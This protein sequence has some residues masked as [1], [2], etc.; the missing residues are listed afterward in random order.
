MDFAEN[1]GISMN[2]SKAELYTDVALPAEELGKDEKGY[3]TF[4]NLENAAKFTFRTVEGTTLTGQD[5]I[6]S[7]QQ[8]LNLQEASQIPHCRPSSFRCSHTCCLRPLPNYRRHRR[9]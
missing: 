5:E 3:T 4:E 7:L 9:Y 2:L 8:I 6:S 1:I